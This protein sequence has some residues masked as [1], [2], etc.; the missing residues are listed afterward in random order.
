M[1]TLHQITAAVTTIEQATAD[2]DRLMQQARDEGTTWRAIAA[3][4]GMT[5]AGVRK[6][7]ARRSRR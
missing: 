2:R 7:L 4:A 6:A 3:A 5:E 1:D